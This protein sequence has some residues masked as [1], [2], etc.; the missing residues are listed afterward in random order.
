VILVFGVLMPPFIAV[1]IVLVLAD[2]RARRDSNP[3]PTGYLHEDQ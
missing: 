2:A 3:Q 1:A